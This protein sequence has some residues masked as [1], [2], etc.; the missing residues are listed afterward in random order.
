M[1]NGSNI[2][3]MIVTLAVLVAL[4][5]WFMLRGTF[6]YGVTVSDAVSKKT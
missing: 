3:V 4:L 6:T 5:V 2:L 1:L